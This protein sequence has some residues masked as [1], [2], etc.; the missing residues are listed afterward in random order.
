MQAVDTVAIVTALL[1]LLEGL[2]HA[3]QVVWAKDVHWA[4]WP[5]G[6]ANNTFTVL[7]ILQLQRKKCWALQSMRKKDGVQ[8]NG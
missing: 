7:S 3:V 4:F 1:L 2:R 5:Y 6:F 8:G